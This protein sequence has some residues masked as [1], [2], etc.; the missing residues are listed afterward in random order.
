LQPQTVP[1]A[2]TTTTTA[3]TAAAVVPEKLTIRQLNRLF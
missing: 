2:A 3:A 1:A